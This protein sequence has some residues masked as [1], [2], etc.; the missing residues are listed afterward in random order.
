MIEHLSPERMREEFNDAFHRVWDTTV[1]LPLVP[2]SNT[3]ELEIS[4]DWI[5]GVVW[6][7]GKWTGS[8]TV[9]SPRKLMKTV[10]A[11]LMNEPE[12]NVDD[13]QY[14]DTIKELTNMFAGNLKSVLPGP[15]GLATPGCFETTAFDEKI[16]E[17]N[18]AEFPVIVSVQYFCEGSPLILTLK[19]V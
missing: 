12:E 3:C 17:E 7:G 15:C 9:V 13:E 16:Y 8:V 4:D 2:Q 1:G 5:G 18:S 11:R 6:L 10:A 19:G 14:K